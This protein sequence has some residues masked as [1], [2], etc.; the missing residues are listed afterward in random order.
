MQNTDIMRSLTEVTVLSFWRLYSMPAFPYHESLPT[1]TAVCC[2]KY[3]WK[4]MVPCPIILF[5]HLY[6]PKI[7]TPNVNG[8]QTS[9]D[10][11]SAKE[12]LYT[13][14][15]INEVLSPTTIAGVPHL[16]RRVHLHPT[17]WN[18]EPWCCKK[19]LPCVT[20]DLS[21]R[22]PELNNTPVLCR[23]NGANNYRTNRIKSYNVSGRVCQGLICET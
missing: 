9:L 16:M 19:H 3:G 12:C 21:Q 10:A 11:Q 4:C 8:N 20:P 22:S 6:A 13:A 23:A 7:T 15:G 14:M 18:L 2:Y 1:Y 17:L 5:L